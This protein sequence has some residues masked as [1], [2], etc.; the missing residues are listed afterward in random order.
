MAVG[1]LGV[2]LYDTTT[3]VRHKLLRAGPCTTWANGACQSPHVSAACVPRG[4][5]TRS[6]VHLRV[7]DALYL[8][9]H[10]PTKAV[11]GGHQRGHG[12][13]PAM[14]HC[15]STISRRNI[16]RSHMLLCAVVLDNVFEPKPKPHA[17]QDGP[18]TCNS[19]C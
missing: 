5:S 7:E 8:T 4:T 15:G 11:E 18:F 16:P 14:N 3:H 6:G 10:R 19:S 9:Q 2:M 13:L 12:N 17:T 1:C